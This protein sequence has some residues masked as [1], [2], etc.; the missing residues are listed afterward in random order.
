MFEDG[1]DLFGGAFG[2]PLAGAGGNYETG[3]PA[4]PAPGQGGGI[5]GDG[6]GGYQIPLTQGGGQQVTPAVPPGAIVIPTDGQAGPLAPSG[7]AQGWQWQGM[8][9]QDTSQGAAVRSAGFTAL[10]VAS[11]VGIGVAVGG[12]WG[13]GAGLLL[14]SALTNGY[15]A[16]KWYDSQN[17][18]EKHE[19][20]VSAVFAAGTLGVGAWMGYKAYQAKAGEGGSAVSKSSGLAKNRKGKKKKSKGKGRSKPIWPGSRGA[21]EDDFDED[22]E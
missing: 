16:Q 6:S 12:P 13:A 19:A 9:P 21:D 17:P 3:T 2:N 7:A 11:A 5:Q 20:V 4:L 14:A 8:E 18:G 22:E 15:R 1:S 10:L